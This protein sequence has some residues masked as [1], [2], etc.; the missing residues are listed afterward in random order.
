[1]GLPIAAVQVGIADRVATMEHPAVTHI[2]AH[3]RNTRCVIGADKEHQITGAGAARSGADVIK[4]LRPQPPEAPAALIVDIADEA[5]AVKG[6]GRTAA[7][8]HIGETEIFFRFFQNGGKGFIIQIGLR[9]FMLRRAVGDVFPD[10]AGRGKQIGAVPQRGH[11]QGVHGKLLLG[12]HVNRDVGEVEVF[13]RDIADVIVVR[14]LHIVVVALAVRPC[15][16][17]VAHLDNHILSQNVLAVKE[18]LQRPA[19]L[20]QCPRALMERGD[21][22]DQHIG[23]VFNGVEV[24]MVLVIIVGTGVGVEVA[25][26]LVLQSAVGGLGSQHIRVLRLIGAG[27]D[28]RKGAVSHGHHR[29]HTRLQ[30]QHHQQAAQRK[31]RPHGMPL[32]ERRRFPDKPLCGRYGLFGGLGGLFGGFPRLALVLPFQLVAMP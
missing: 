23:I 8:P 20:V 3:M 4:A 26:Q 6:C 12:H 25:L 9:D 21:H 7:A 14:H 11:I 17:A 30:G 15:D 22:G 31:Q 16:R 29:G 27:G 10:I 18:V 24:K 13:Q 19:H 32:D 2:D 1:M 5:G 28:G